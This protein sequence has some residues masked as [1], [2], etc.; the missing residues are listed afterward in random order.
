M[1]DGEVEIPERRKF[2]LI[3]QVLGITGKKLESQIED[4]IED[5]TTT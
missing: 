4:A 1:S 2:T 5:V 3:A